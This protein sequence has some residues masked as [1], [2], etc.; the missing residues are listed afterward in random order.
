MAWWQWVVLVA[1]IGCVAFLVISR[2]KGAAA[3]GPGKGPT[4]GIIR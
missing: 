4:K 1:I 3:S 2:K